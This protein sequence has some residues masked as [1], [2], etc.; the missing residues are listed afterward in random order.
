MSALNSADIAGPRD[1]GFARFAETRAVRRNLSRHSVRGFSY[2]FGTN[3][4]EFVARI[5][6]TSILARLISPEHFGLVMMVGA[7]TAIADQF[8]DL[9]LSTATIQRDHITRQEV[10]NLFWIN[11]GAGTLLAAAVSVSAPLVANYFREPRLV[12]V[13]LALSITPLLG[14]LSVQHEAL[15]GRQMKV[16]RKSAMR[17][18][19]FILSSGLAIALAMLGYGYWALVWREVSRSALIVIGAWALCPWLP[20]RPDL[21]T[22]VR[23]LVK[24]G[25]GLTAT[26]IFGAITSS[27]DRFI[28]GR[29]KGADVVGLYRQSNQLVVMPMS[30]LMGPL[31]QVSLPSLSMLQNDARKFA[32]FY[33]YV[34][35]AVATVSMP[36]NAF[37]AIYADDI[38]LVLLGPRWSGAATFI[39]IF[40]IGGLVQSVF[41]TIGFVLVSRGHSGALL[42][43]STATNVLRA[44]LMVGGLRWGAV[45][46]ASGDVLTTFVMFFP[47][48]HFALLA[49][50]VTTQDFLRALARPFAATVVVAVASGAIKLSLLPNTSIFSIVAGACFA[51]FVFVATWLLLPGGSAE[52]R[53]IRMAAT[54][55]LNRA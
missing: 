8:R 19:A 54:V 33:A 12:Q 50:P 52:L 2:V 5:V 42:R 20:G 25:S 9:G 38:T 18:V 44:I 27:L 26:Y 49:S 55:G 6:A 51:A 11:V 36:L 23:P 30:Q 29:F 43:L 13:S 14:G 48:L 37:I 32:R 16:G 15:L 10:S 24:F 45:G 40:A 4:A 3:A 28:L 41:S 31:Y 7:V 35:S 39:R 22:D 17:L 53:A 34:V 1:D 21:G 46:V 47:Y